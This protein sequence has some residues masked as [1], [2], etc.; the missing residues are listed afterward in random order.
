M[1]Q[2]CSLSPMVE[3]PPDEIVEPLQMSWVDF[4]SPRVGAAIRMYAC[5][6]LCRRIRAIALI[7]NSIVMP[8][9]ESFATLQRQS[10]QR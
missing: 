2:L 4:R 1:Q 3:V 6:G 7:P 10:R 8:S 9:E 5:V